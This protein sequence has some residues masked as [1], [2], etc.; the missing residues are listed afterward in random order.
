MSRGT[1]IEVVAL[2]WPICLLCL[3][4]MVSKPSS[5]VWV[6]VMM[7]M[8]WQAAVLPLFNM[9]A[10]FTGLWHFSDGAWMVLGMPASLYFGWVVMWGGCAVFIQN[11]LGKWMP[12]FGR[13]SL[14]V[15]LFGMFILDLIVMPLMSPVL[16][17]GDMW[18]LGEG[19]IILGALL[20]GLCLARWV[21]NDRHV[22]ARAALISGAFVVLLL[23]VLPLVGDGR[24][25][26]ELLRVVTSRSSLVNWIAVAAGAVA[27]V[28]GLSAVRQFVIFGQ[29]TPI[30]FDPPKKLVTQGVYAYISNPMQWS[31]FVALLI[32]AWIW[33]SWVCLGLAGVSILYAQGLAAWSETSDLKHRYGK[34]WARYRLAVPRWRVSLFPYVEKPTSPTTGSDDLE[35]K[36]YVSMTCKIC[37]ELAQWFDARYPMGLSICAAEDFDGEALERVT[38]VAAGGSIH[39]SGVDAVACALQHLHVGWAYL[40]W[41]M[42]LPGVM[43]ILQLAMDASG[44]GKRSGFAGR[45]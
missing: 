17:L 28:P 27:I 10:S 12:G 18:L 9:A 33:Q 43:Q 40:G 13:W 8:A 20:P 31:M 30:P 42:Q 29:G 37:S 23:F 19:G 44:A 22:G 1:I 24:D 35:A 36:L 26:P 25:V 21:V 39:A 11:A 32:W 45:F 6:G 14:W 2:Y 3:L 5:R 34:A 15:T 16:V 7:A 41:M 38:Y 4:V